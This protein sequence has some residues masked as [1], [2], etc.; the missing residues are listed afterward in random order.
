MDKISIERIA[1]AHPKIRT[2]LLLIYNEANNRLAKSRLRF[3]HVLRTFKEQSD[4]FAIGRTTGKKG[5]IVTN[6]KAGQSF[7]N[8]GLAV[9]I[10]LL[11]DKDGDGRFE[12]ASWDVFKDW[13][14][15]GI[16]DWKEVVHVFKKYGWTWGGDFRFKDMPHFQKTFGKTW[17]ELKKLHDS[18]KVDCDGFV[19]I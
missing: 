1:K 6:A 5:A 9:D 15:D 16:A 7:H 10:V 3:S 4:L 17:Q 11:I 19:Q 2:E 12:S 8:Y 14:K 18:G 13:D